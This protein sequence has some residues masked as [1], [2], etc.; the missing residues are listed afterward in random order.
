MELV[1]RAP[2]SAQA[3]W[4]LLGEE[5]RRVLEL[6]QD[7]ARDKTPARMEESVA[8]IRW[9]S[10]GKHRA[11]VRDGMIVA[12]FRHYESRAGKPLLHDHAVVSIRPGGRTGSGGTCP[13]PTSSTTSWRPARFTPSTSWR[14]SLPG[15]GGRG[16]RAR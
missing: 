2:S 8:Q 6:C 12:V 7:I 5:H 10:G 14:R 3:A 13:P 16:S 15:S 4:A 11:P 9:G 1:Y